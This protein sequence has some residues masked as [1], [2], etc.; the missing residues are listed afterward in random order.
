MLLIFPPVAK[1]CEPPAGVALLSSAL[2]E[3]GLPCKVYDANI[4]GL[5]YLIN[6]DIAPIDSWSRRAL[7]NRKEKPG[8][9][10]GSKIFNKKSNINKKKISKNSDSDKKL[11]TSLLRKNE[12]A[13]ILFGAF[14]LTI[15]IFFFFF[16]SSNSKSEVFE[17][18][19]SSASFSDFEMRIQNIEK[20]LQIGHSLKSEGVNFKESVTQVNH[21]KDRL[22]RLETA[23]SVKFDSLIDRIGKIEKSISQLENKTV[24]KESEPKAAVPVKKAVKKKSQFHMVKKEET[25][26]SISKQYNISIDKLRELNKLSKGATIY[27]GDNL[28]VR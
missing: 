3:Q 17:Q 2:K 9:K 22:G 24:K 11:K 27:P 10:I 20:A 15:L 21:I 26:Y 4:E 28:L 25:L 1:P 14:L 5:L 16:R 12:F 23:F 6:S 19:V 8:S 7:K 18:N 13:L